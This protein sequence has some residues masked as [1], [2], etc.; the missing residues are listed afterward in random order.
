M[1]IITERRGGLGKLF[2]ASLVVSFILGL[3]EHTQHLPSTASSSTGLLAVLWG[4]HIYGYRAGIMAVLAAL[5]ALLALWIRV[6]KRVVRPIYALGFWLLYLTVWG[7]SYLLGRVMDG[8]SWLSVDHPLCSSLGYVPWPVVL[9]TPFL[10]G[11]LLLLVARWL[12][13]E[14]SRRGYVTII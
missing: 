5:A 10:L 1:A 8:G 2:I 11:P 12:D 3:I 14:L 4:V 7:S 6:E 13:L 9:P